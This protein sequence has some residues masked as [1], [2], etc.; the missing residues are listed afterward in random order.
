MIRF[1]TLWGL[2]LSMENASLS[3]EIQ[4]HAKNILRRPQYFRNYERLKCVIPVLMPKSLLSALFF[5]YPLHFVVAQEDWKL[6]DEK[7]GIK[8][9]MRSVAGSDIKALKVS[10]SIQAT[11]SQMAAVILDVATTDQWVYSTRSC[12]LLKQISP[13]EVVYHSEIN[14]PWPASNRDFIARIRVTQDPVT[15][16]MT[17]ESFNEPSYVPEKDGVV[18]VPHADGKWTIKPAAPSQLHVEYMLHIDP[19]GAIPAW[20]INLFATKG[21]F[22]SFRNMREHIRKP[23]YQRVHI[24]FVA[25]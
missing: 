1:Y 6:R 25:D 4:Q 17:V 21:P 14:V 2:F 10:F 13:Q 5:I 16:I 7:E 18:R 3:P 19:G 22:E 9:Y 15:R 23:A 20:L 12:T 8:I 24:P 11:M